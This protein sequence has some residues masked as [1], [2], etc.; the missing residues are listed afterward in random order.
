MPQE[1]GS[2]TSTV[3]AESAPLVGLEAFDMYVKL[4]STHVEILQSLIPKLEV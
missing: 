4:I 2:R 1:M 3:V